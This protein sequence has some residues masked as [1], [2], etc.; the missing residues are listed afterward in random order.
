MIRAENLCFAFTERDIFRDLSLT[1]ERGEFLTILGPNGCGKS[2]LLRLLRGSLP[3]RSGRITWNGTALDKISAREMARCVAVVPQTTH[4]GFPYRVSELVAMGRYPHRKGLFELSGSAD[5]K[6]IRHAL[7]LTDTLPLADRPVTRLSGGE[8]QRVL[9][10]RAL[11]QETEILFL[12]EATSHLDIDHRLELSELLVRLNREQ[13]VTLVQVSHDLDLAAAVSGRIL[14][15]TEHGNIAGLGTPREVMTAENL[16]RVFRVELK[17]ADNPYTG[18]PQIIPLINRPTVRLDGLGIHLICGGGSGRVLL[19]RLH[20][21]NARLSA[22]PLNHGDS[23]EEIAGAIEIPV[24]REVA[25]H[26]FSA[27]VLGK[28]EELS[29]RADVLVV[30]TGCWGTGNLACLDLAQKALERGMPVYLLA[31]A[32]EHDFT[33]GQAWEKIERLQQQGAVTLQ[34]DDQLLEELGRQTGQR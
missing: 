26:P 6:A 16:R 1:V 17:V 32:P 14:L 12:D 29:G 30:A 28:A 25:F 13:G 24:V 9:L 21:A 11:A 20:L 22:G 4:V 23:D 5:R 8:L 2:T 34:N 3:A 33:G 10:A 15:L 18:T 31:P 7:A 27:A 19:R